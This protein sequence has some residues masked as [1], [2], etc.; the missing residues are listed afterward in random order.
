[1]GEWYQFTGK[2]KKKTK[3]NPSFAFNLCWAK[4]AVSSMLS[5]GYRKK[6]IFF[7]DNEYFYPIK[8]QNMMPDEREWWESEAEISRKR[9]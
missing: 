8:K 2:K 7:F 1:M 6:K 9:N 3:I 4:V 5:K